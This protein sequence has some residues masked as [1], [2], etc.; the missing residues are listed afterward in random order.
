[1]TALLVS[2]YPSTLPAPSA[3]VHAPRDRRRLSDPA[4]PREANALQIDRAAIEKATFPPMTPA[5]YAA[6]REWWDSDLVKGGRWFVATWPSPRGPIEIVRR[7]VEPPA[8]SFVP[9]GFFQLSATF[10]VRGAGLLPVRN[11]ETVLLMHFNGDTVDECG[12]TF[13]IAPPGYVSYQD[14]PAAGFGEAVY[15]AGARGLTATYPVSESLLG[16]G[17]WQIDVFLTLDAGPSQGEILVLSKDDDAVTQVLFFELRAVISETGSPNIM[18]QTL[19]RDAPGSLANITRTAIGSRDVI[20]G[21]RLH[22]R[23]ANYAGNLYQWHDGTLVATRAAGTLTF[24][25]PSAAFMR[26]CVG[27]TPAGGTLPDTVFT[28]YLPGT[29]DELRIA[30]EVTD[31]PPFDVPSR[32]FTI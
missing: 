27:M 7:F 1:M 19:V 20:T 2:R 15:F 25:A 14:S 17:E 11:P 6:F 5:Q 22:V 4:R 9:G 10:E 28:G 29:I 31:A 3:L 26:A 12:A 30:Q 8:W 21:E 18:I 13:S 16:S 23:V 24:D 32:P